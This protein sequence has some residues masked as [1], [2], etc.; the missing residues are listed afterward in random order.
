M[1]IQCFV[2]L[3]TSF[4]QLMAVDLEQKDSETVSLM[5]LEI[6]GMYHALNNFCMTYLIILACDATIINNVNHK[7][8]HHHHHRHH[9]L[10]P[11]LVKL[12]K[13]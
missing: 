11:F 10:K 9:F 1:E 12:Y 7:H 13:R 3:M 5:L 4:S 8:H 2:I 6:M